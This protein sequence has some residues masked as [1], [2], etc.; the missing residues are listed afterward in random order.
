MTDARLAALLAEAVLQGG[1]PDA[2][3]A[4]LIA[5]AILQGGSP[6]VRLGASLVE[7]V[8]KGGSPEVQI[9]ALVAEAILLN[10]D[11]NAIL[12][13]DGSNALRLE[14]GSQ[15]LLDK[16][17]DDFE[18][19]DSAALGTASGG[20]SW[21]EIPGDGW[22]IE[23]GKAVRRQEG[24]TDPSARAETD[25]GSADHFAEID[26]ATLTGDSS[27]TNQVA[28]AVRFD[29]AAHT[30]Y[31]A[32]VS[33]ENPSTGAAL[34]RI[35]KVVGGTATVLVES[36][37]TAAP[38]WSGKIRCE[39]EGSTIRMYRDGVLR[40]EITDTS[41]T[42]HMRTGLGRT[43]AN[44]SNPAGSIKIES[45]LAGLIT[46]EETVTELTTADT[47]TGAETSTV[48]ASTPVAAADTGVGTETASVTKTASLLTADAGSGVDS[49]QLES[50][51][52][53]AAS[54]TG[55][56]ADSTSVDKGALL[57]V[58]DTGT[59]VDSSSLFQGKKIDAF[60]SGSG[61]DSAAVE[62]AFVV[63]DSAAGADSSLTSKSIS[64][65]DSGSGS[66]SASAS[67]VR[68]F[69]L[70]DSGTG[71]DSATATRIVDVADAGTG[72]DSSAVTKTIYKGVT[73]TGTATDV[74]SLIRAII[75]DPDLGNVAITATDVPSSYQA[76]IVIKPPPGEF[77]T[78]TELVVR[79]VNRLG[80]RIT[81]LHQAEVESMSWV[82]NGIGEAIIKVPTR[83]PKALKIE[84]AKT[85]I[86]IFHGDNVIWWGVPW[87]VEGGSHELQI[88]CDDL[89]SYLN[90]WYVTNTTLEY[91]D[92]DQFSIMWDVIS[93]HN[94]PFYI[95]S[96]NQGTTHYEYSEVLRYRR[97]LREEHQN[98][99]DILNEF[100]TLKHGFD[101]SMW[102]SAV[103]GNIY[104][105]IVFHYPQK[106]IRRPGM[107]L[108]WGRN[109][110]SFKFNEDAVDM[111]NHVYVTGGQ[112]NNVKFEENY[113]DEG[114]A[115]EYGTLIDVV[116]EGS[117]LDPDHLR[118]RAEQEVLERKKPLIIPEVT[119][120][121]H[122]VQVFK[123]LEVGDIVPVR[124]D[125]GRAQVADELRVA[126]ITWRP[127]DV[128][129]LVF[130]E[131]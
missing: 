69:A 14:D 56:G 20:W 123:V 94:G 73:D 97:Y 1:T 15:L 53:F 95:W 61:T 127:G 89:L 67:S 106:G 121:D 114:A 29:P 86:Q 130:N 99:L 57:S 18:R 93:K 37:W 38:P 19:A 120:V 66:D 76:P 44:T 5:E 103:P 13:E 91:E 6:E 45:F 100:P 70:A 85:E 42:G 32:V 40:H 107:V 75:S 3:A 50:E 48:S 84:L 52:S 80:E 82:L 35:I 119:V 54:D 78:E 65:S 39:V 23:A 109:I 92:V 116:S 111:A 72:V 125:C 2:R 115:S 104:K 64:T 88:R 117:V 10:F 62:K 9:G 60:D 7:A 34:D 22:Y 51:Q 68:E 131:A 105:R 55:A 33:L 98:V 46:P 87:Q 30:H 47:G 101:F 96:G 113:I 25:L 79:V 83:D 12:L 16:I 17:F 108:E 36:A 4:A 126:S 112:A 128:L 77:I 74:S 118:E 21:T 90:K 63:S 71:I 124:I 59:G 43:F 24:S 28:V 8:L 11:P 27:F 41:I 122:P 129:D 102:L 31:A 26:V 110:K 81:E 58:A 49:T